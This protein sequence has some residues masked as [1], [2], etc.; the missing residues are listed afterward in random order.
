[1]KKLALITSISYVVPL[2]ISQFKNLEKRDRYS[3]DNSNKLDLNTILTSLT[4]SSDIEFNGHFGANVFFSLSSTNIED[5]EVIAKIIKAYA[6]KKS[7]FDIFT[8]S[9]QSTYNH[10]KNTGFVSPF[11][12]A[13]QCFKT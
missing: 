13:V 6:N 2:S 4:H 10:K 7:Y 9:L 1:M 3:L 5:S 8:L 12:Y 11:E